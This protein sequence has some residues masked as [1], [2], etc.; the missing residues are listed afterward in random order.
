MLYNVEFLRFIFC[1]GI[2][3]CHA[4]VGGHNTFANEFVTNHFLGMS[5]AVN[6]FFVIGGY[7]LFFQTLKKDLTIRD[8]IVKKYIRLLPVIIFSM[9]MIPIYR[10][11]GLVSQRFNF[12]DSFLSLFLIRTVGLYNDAKNFDLFYTNAHLWYIGPLFWTSLFYFSISKS[13]DRNKTNL[14]IAIITYVLFLS[15]AN[16]IKVIIPEYAVRALSNMG[17]GYF[18]GL[19]ANYHSNLIGRR[20]GDVYGGGKE[21]RRKRESYSNVYRAAIT[22][23]E[24]FLFLEI[25]KVLFI[26]TKPWREF[27]FYYSMC[28][29]VLLFLFSI[30]I[31]W[32][33]R[34]TNNRIM[35]SLSKYCYSIYVMQYSVQIL[36]AKDNRLGESKIYLSFVNTH[37]VVD[38]IVNYVILEFIVG[39]VVYHL[40]EKPCYKYLERKF[41]Q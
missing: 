8:F 24:G 7:L 18:V 35:G 19:L 34:L 9:L 32:L 20:E 30:K 13:F 36:L 12:R 10:K 41:I 23:V 22:C 28:F 17:L 2:L 33:S 39:I 25:F 27:E 6:F 26:K 15:H 31:G 1:I 38:I 11:F 4:S 37:P 16:T 29:A 3:L 40:V 21:M 14:V 5:F